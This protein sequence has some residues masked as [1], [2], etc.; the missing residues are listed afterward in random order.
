M[1]N[2]VSLNGSLPPSPKKEE[3]LRSGFAARISFPFNATQ[4]LTIVAIV[5]VVAMPGIVAAI[6]HASQTPVQIYNATCAPLLLTPLTVAAYLRRGIVAGLA[7]Q[8]EVTADRLKLN[9]FRKYWGQPDF[10]KQRRLD[11]EKFNLLHKASEDYVQNAP[12]HPA[13]RAIALHQAKAS[14]V[15]AYQLNKSA[16]VLKSQ[17]QDLRFKE[18]EACQEAAELAETPQEILDWVARGLQELKFPLY[19]PQDLICHDHTDWP[20]CN[21]AISL[22]STA[23]EAFLRLPSGEID[24]SNIARRVDTSAIFSGTQ[25]AAAQCLRYAAYYTKMLRH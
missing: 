24:Y 12:D 8:T 2:S 22:W 20:K 23:A 4:T 3:P 5:F 7:N 11:E 21:V 14:L 15:Q 19:P 9:D 6:P 10:A 13:A 1:T 16:K 17:I 18:A 25:A